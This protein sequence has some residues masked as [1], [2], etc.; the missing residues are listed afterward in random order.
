MVEEEG[1]CLMLQMSRG[2]SLQ[3][4][5]ALLGGDRAEGTDR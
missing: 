1:D 5:S 2:E 4:G 3:L